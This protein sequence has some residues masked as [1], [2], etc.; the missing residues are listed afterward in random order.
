MLAITVNS[1][2]LVIPIINLDYFS[3]IG[4]ICNPSN[5]TNACNIS[6]VVNFRNMG[7][8]NYSFKPSKWAGGAY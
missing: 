1:V 7:N 4:N 5:F 8:I 2:I 6:N 3:S